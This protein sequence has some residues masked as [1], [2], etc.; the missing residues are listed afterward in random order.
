MRY[1]RKKEATMKPKS[2]KNSSEYIALM[3]MAGAA[4]LGE[5]VSSFLSEID[6]PGNL[7]ALPLVCGNVRDALSE[8]RSAW[9]LSSEISALDSWDKPLTWLCR[10]RLLIIWQWHSARRRLTPQMGTTRFG[11]GAS[12][13]TRYTPRFAAPLATESSQPNTASCRRILCWQI[14]CSCVGMRR[15]QSMRPTKAMKKFSEHVPSQFGGVCCPANQPE[16]WISRHARFNHASPRFGE[17]CR[18]LEVR[19]ENRSMSR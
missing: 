7:T 8:A 2:P 15:L 19:M 10:R 6:A 1:S 18:A 5:E 12:G 9:G 16:T 4:Q 3:Q 14:P 11:D 13:D 17:H